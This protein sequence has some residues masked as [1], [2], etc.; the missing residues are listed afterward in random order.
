MPAAPAFPTVRLHFK[1]LWEPTVPRADM[2]A[3]MQQTYAAVGIS[4]A[5]ASQE[6][7]K[8]LTTMAELDVGGCETEGELT[9]EEDKLFECR[10]YAHPDQTCV[11]FVRSLSPPVYCGCGTRKAKLP[12][13]KDGRPSVVIGARATRWTLGHECGHV[14]GI[15]HVPQTDRLMYERTSQITSPVPVLTAAEGATMK[16]SQFLR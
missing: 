1:V 6:D 4:V 5:V 14:L 15:G 16:K 10:K 7:L 13:F 3:A 12:G 11:Y 9:D 2:V 8:H